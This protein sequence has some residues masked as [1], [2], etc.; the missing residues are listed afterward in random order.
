MIYMKKY[1]NFNDQLAIS[2]TRELFS[3]KMITGMGPNFKKALE[4]IARLKFD[5][6]NRERGYCTW[7]A[8]EN[9]YIIKDLAL[10]LGFNIF[11]KKS[12]SVGG[13]GGMINNNAINLVL[14]S[15]TAYERVVFDMIVKEALEKYGIDLDSVLGAD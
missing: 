2:W 3:S 8:V 1:F 11:P 14:N 4:L 15:F 10:I 12:T 13:P 5:N 6:W 7:S 9:G